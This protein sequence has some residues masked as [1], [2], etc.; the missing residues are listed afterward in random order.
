[1]RTGHTACGPL[2]RQ[3]R[4]PLLRLLCAPGR[5]RQA[6]ALS[7]F[8]AAVGGGA[9]P[10]QAGSTAEAPGHLPQPPQPP[11]PTH[12]LQVGRVCVFHQR[13]QRRLN[14]ALQPQA[15]APAC[16]CGCSP[17]PLT[18]M[19]ASAGRIGA[20]AMQSTAW[21]CQV[22]DGRAAWRPV[23]GSKTA[24]CQLPMQGC[25]CPSGMLRYAPPLPLARRG[26]PSLT[27]ARLAGPSSWE[28]TH[29]PILPSPPF[30]PFPPRPAFSQQVPIANRH[31]AAVA[32][33][34]MGH[35]VQHLPAN[36]EQW[37]GA[38]VGAANCGKRKKH[39]PLP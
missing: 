24:S 28:G 8:S 10:K 6:A 9:P 19:T 16:R 20:Q 34:A 32:S 18:G 1:M 5:R 26:C 7:L 14:R 29:T 31:G 35:I 21:Q 4:Q 37:C 3:P 22:G 2:D 15:V 23:Q 27:M 33:H 11:T 13:L 25:C 39:P 36:S 17:Q 30:P 38:Q 12:R